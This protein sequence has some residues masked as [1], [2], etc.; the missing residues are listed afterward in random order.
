MDAVEVSRVIHLLAIAF[1]VGGQFVIA[2]AVPVLKGTDQ[3]TALARR[4]GVAS[5]VA[6]GVA[7]LTGAMMASENDRWSDPVLHAKLALLV[8]VL[9]VTALHIRNGAKAWMH[10]VI[11][12]GSVTILVL[13]VALAHNW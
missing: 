6:I 1:F 2:L 5:L 7:I 10:P 11:A 3:M 8:V 13:G 4:F 9:V 12:L